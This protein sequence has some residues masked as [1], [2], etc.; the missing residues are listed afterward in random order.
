MSEKYLIWSNEHRC[1]WYANSQGYT[2]VIENAGRYTREE[3]MEICR[4]L[5]GKVFDC[6]RIPDEIPIRESDAI[7]LEWNNTP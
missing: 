7:E 2:T 6:S 4:S 5:H 3:A 1:W